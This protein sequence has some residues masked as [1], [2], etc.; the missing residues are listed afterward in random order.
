MKFY[1]FGAQGQVGSTLSKKLPFAFCYTQRTEN[2]SEVSKF[3]LG[4]SEDDV[5]FIASSLTAVDLC[6]RDPYASYISN[7]LSVK[8]IVDEAKKYDATVVFYSSDYVFDGIRGRNSIEDI[9]M[10]INT[11]GLHKVYAE[12]YIMQHMKKYHII[13]TNM[14]YGQDPNNKNYLSRILS[15]VEKNE[16]I[17]APQDEWVTPTY[18]VNLVKV[19]LELVKQREYGVF[20]VAGSNKITRY[21][22]T[23][24]VLEFIGKSSCLTKPVPSLKL[25]RAA[26]RPLNG[27]LTTT[28]STGDLAHSLTDIFVN[29]L[30]LTAKVNVK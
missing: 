4:A 3:L 11:Y 5:I 19:T 16:I 30:L 10:P 26:R 20:H 22:F 2:I 9:V 14:V 28:H 12:N 23:C 18:N 6:E 25:G 24:H 27:G 17:E 21:D 7:V 1:I 15:M 13:R 8:H 29:D